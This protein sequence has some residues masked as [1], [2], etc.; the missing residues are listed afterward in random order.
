MFTR[1][2]DR[3]SDP[4][5]YGVLLPVPRVAEKLRQE[6]AQAGLKIAFEWQVDSQLLASCG[7]PVAPTLVMGVFAP[8]PS[9]RSAIVDPPSLLAT[10]MAV[11][12]VEWTDQ[13]QI[14]CPPAPSGV[15]TEDSHRLR[16]AIY[17]TGARV[18]ASYSFG[19]RSSQPRNTAVAVLEEKPK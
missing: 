2:C 5:T 16:D 7:V 12:L 17:A 3:E 14:F 8:V 15:G 18:T 4:L 10:V 6:I 13:T 11:L 9:L 1:Q 19:N